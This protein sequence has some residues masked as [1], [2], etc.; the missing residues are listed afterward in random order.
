MLGEV[1]VKRFV[2]LDPSQ[3]EVFDPPGNKVFD[4]PEME[5]F[6]PPGMEVFEPPGM[7]KFEPPGMEKFEPPVMEDL[8]RFEVSKLERVKEGEVSISGWMITFV[9]ATVPVLSS[10]LCVVSAPGVIVFNPGFD[11]VEVIVEKPFE[12]FK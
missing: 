11:V 2:E 5:E 1:E 4:P 10:L 12:P 6:D 8:W 7:E 9:R 3:V